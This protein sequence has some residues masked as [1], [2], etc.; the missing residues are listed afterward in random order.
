MLNFLQLRM[1]GVN[2]PGQS[3]SVIKDWVTKAIS[4][5]NDHY[6]SL[7][8]KDQVYKNELIGDTGERG[9]AHSM[10]S[11]WSMQLLWP[12]PRMNAAGK[13]TTSR[14]QCRWS[15]MGMNRKSRSKMSLPCSKKGVITVCKEKVHEKSHG[16][17]ISSVQRGAI[18][19]SCK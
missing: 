1:S 9:D 16:Q 4:G 5:V 12:L 3:Q 10:L 8:I 15:W 13:Q 18:L 11:R 17:R 6:H 2:E 14:L 19:V 7:E